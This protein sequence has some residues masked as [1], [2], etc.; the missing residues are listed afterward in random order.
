M[1]LL[2]LVERSKQLKVLKAGV[3]IRHAAVVME[4]MVDPCFAHNGERIES[5]GAAATGI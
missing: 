4:V 5:C 2:Q 3:L 1:L